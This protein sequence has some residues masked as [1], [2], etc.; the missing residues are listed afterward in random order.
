MACASSSL[1]GHSNGHAVVDAITPSVEG[2]SK[3]V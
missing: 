1:A 3:E 2:L